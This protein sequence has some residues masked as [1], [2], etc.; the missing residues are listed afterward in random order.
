M[1]KF[2]T[3][4]GLEIHVQLQ[5]A[6]KLFCGCTNAFGGHP[7]SRTCPV[8]LGMPGALPV[9]NQKAVEFAVRAA[10]ALGCEVNLRSRFARKNYFYPDL[11]KGYQISQYDQPIAGRGV[12][13]F[14]C[15]GRR[16]EVRLLRLHLEEDAGKSIHSSMPRSGTKS[17]VDLNRCG[18]PLIEIVSEPDLRSPAEASAFVTALRNTL[19]YVGVTDANMDEGSLRCDANISMRRCGEEHLNPKSELK[20]LNSFRFL[21][22][23]LRFEVE[24]QTALLKAGEPLTQSTRLFDERTGKTV[25]MRAKEEAHDYRYFPEPDLVPVVLDETE[26]AKASKGIPQLPL[27]RLDAFVEEL[28]LSYE[29]ASTLVEERARADY[30][31]ALIQAGASISE[32]NKWVSNEIGRW[33]NEHNSDFA[34]FPVSAEVLTSLVDAVQ[35]G[36]VP[37]GMAGKVMDRMAETG[38]DVE[39]ILA[40]EDLQQISASD[41]LALF[42]DK[43]VEAHP[44]EVEAIRG[45]RDQVFGFLMGEVM[46]AT[47]GKANPDTARKLLRERIKQ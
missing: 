46:R 43:V 3:V 9:L 11:P 5:T 32:A 35:S 45:G 39:T 38:S 40:E 8:C 36:T 31:E 44:N 42:V 1:E 2:E 18:V 12:F 27:A 14:D 33:L 26:V 17:Y 34:A 23:A 47:K 22:Q 13:Y 20:N 16:A 6:T 25:S 29:D 19:L 7:N 28:G 30:F 41:E 4:I 10:L 15:D 24:R 37:A 21:R